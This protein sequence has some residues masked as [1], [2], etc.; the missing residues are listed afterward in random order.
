MK[1]A[2]VAAVVLGAALALG[3]AGNPLQPG[4]TATVTLGVGQPVSAGTLALTLVSVTNDSRCPINA[5]C[6][7]AGDATLTI[8][9]RDGRNVERR[10]LLVND[11]VR[12]R[13]TFAGSTIEVVSL[14]PPRFS[15]G[16]IAQSEYRATVNVS[17]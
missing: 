4:E 17:R 10:E 15:P 1:H 16:T 3:C 14:I 8:D 6:V 13:T 2:K 11:P 12:K 5:L 9:F 7:V